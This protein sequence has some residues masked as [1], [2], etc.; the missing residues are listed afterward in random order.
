MKKKRQHRH[1]ECRHRRPSSFA[2]Q[3]SNRVFRDLGLRTGDVFLDIGC[4]AGDYAIHAARLIGNLGRVYALDKSPDLVSRLGRRATAEGV[5]NITAIT[6]DATEPLPI[7]DG[8]VDVCLVATVLHIPEVTRNAEHLFSEIRRVLQPNGYTAIIEC[9]S[10]D[11]SH[12]PPQEMRLPPNQ[13][14][15]IAAP[16]GFRKTSEL[17]FGF[18]YMLKL[19]C[20]LKPRFP[21]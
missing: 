14:Q 12:G 10:R 18:N 8:S 15:A 16:F 20:A 6:A 21:D 13:V 3:D 2:M 4:G 9:N 1:H 7:E 19:S 17:D 11:L 5:T